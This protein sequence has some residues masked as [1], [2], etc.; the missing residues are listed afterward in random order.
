MNPVAPVPPVL[1]NQ[2]AFTYESPVTN[3]YDGV[4]PLG[5]ADG[6]VA[7]TSVGPTL[8]GYTLWFGRVGSTVE[9]QLWT[10]PFPPA[11]GTMLASWSGTVDSPAAPYIA[12]FGAITGIP[13]DPFWGNPIIQVDT[14]PATVQDNSVPY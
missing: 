14:D 9:L 8:H 7:Q 10:D 5:P 12:D 1:G 2:L 11:A 4:T 6:W 3:L 13:L